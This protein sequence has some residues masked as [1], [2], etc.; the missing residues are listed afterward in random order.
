MTDK[1][2]GPL[3]D[4]ARIQELLNELGWRCAAHGIVADLLIVGG[5]AIA[6]AYS[7]DRATRDIDAIFEPKMLVY[8]EAEKMANEFGNSAGLAKR[9][10]EGRDARLPRRW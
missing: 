1:A 10:R 9:C 8:Q 6:L 2:N 4:R 7:N 3:L 5:G